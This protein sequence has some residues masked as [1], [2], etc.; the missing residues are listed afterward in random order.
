MT[1]T[2][3]K[4]ITTRCVF[5]LR[6]DVCMIRPQRPSISD[7]PRASAAGNP[8]RTARNATTSWRRITRRA[9]FR[10][11]C[12]RTSARSPLS[13]GRYYTA[14]TSTGENG[15]QPESAR[16]P[17]QPAQPAPDMLN[18]CSLVRRGR[19]VCSLYTCLCTLYRMHA[20]P[21]R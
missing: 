16:R 17:S 8:T 10:L 15:S 1:T 6:V 21:P 18:V 20:R 12:G 7:R 19:A 14:L 5:T 11:P 2:R 4:V 13:V 9:K 3:R